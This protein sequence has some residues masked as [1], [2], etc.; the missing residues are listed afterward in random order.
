MGGSVLDF[1]KSSGEDELVK[2]STHRFS[3]I[4]LIIRK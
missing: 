1:S 4:D 3:G 2:G